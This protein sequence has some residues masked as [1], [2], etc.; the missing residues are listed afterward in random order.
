MEYYFSIE[1]INRDIYYSRKN[2]PLL[3]AVNYCHFVLD[4]FKSHIYLLSRK[5][6]DPL[7]VS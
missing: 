3:T 5:Q 7:L 2:V 1:E 6:F 4:H